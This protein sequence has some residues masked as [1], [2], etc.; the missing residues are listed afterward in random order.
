MKNSI[1]QCNDISL[2][3]LKFIR[4]GKM[5]CFCMFSSTDLSYGQVSINRWMDK[6]I[7]ICMCSGILLSHKRDLVFHH[8]QQHGWTG[9]GIVRVK[10]NLGERQTYISNWTQLATELQM[11]IWYHLNFEILK[12]NKLM[13]IATKKGES[14]FTMKTNWWL[15]VGKKRG[16]TR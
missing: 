7:S 3:Y 11:R 6:K 15:P 10:S 1:T 12:Y 2:V 14:L 9:R 8:L 16:R 5:H 13:N 4:L